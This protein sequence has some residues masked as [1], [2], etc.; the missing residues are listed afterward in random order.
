MTP[1]EEK[2]DSEVPDIIDGTEEDLDR[3]IEYY[4]LL[5]AQHY[6]LRKVVE[7]DFMRILDYLKR[8]REATRTEGLKI[9]GEVI[10]YLSVTVSQLKRSR[11]LLSKQMGEVGEYIDNNEGTVE[12]VIKETPFFSLF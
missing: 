9:I 5:V 1:N 12:E 10:D 2:A 7:I 11:E 4:T 3:V 8:A 6:R